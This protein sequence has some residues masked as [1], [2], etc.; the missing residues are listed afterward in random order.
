LIG[1][2]KTQKAQNKAG[3]TRKPQRQE[4][5]TGKAFLTADNT[6]CADMGEAKL[7][8][9]NFLSYPSLPLHPS[10]DNLR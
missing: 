7:S 9:K 2:E 10:R 8:P 3:F 5:E 4:V 1:R 6:D